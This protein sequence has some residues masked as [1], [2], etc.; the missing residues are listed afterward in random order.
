MGRRGAAASRAWRAV[1]APP[2]LP[3]LGQHGLRA[4][5]CLPCWLD[6]EHRAGTGGQGCSVLPRER[7]VERGPI[8]GDTCC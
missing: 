4:L 6:R 2:S 1:A 7:L 5:A 8:R 3:A